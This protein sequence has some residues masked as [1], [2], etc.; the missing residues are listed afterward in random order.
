MKLQRAVIDSL[1][2]ANFY[3]EDLFCNDNYSIELVKGIGVFKPER[4]L[5]TFGIVTQKHIIEAKILHTSK[6][7]TVPFK[8]FSSSQNMQT[9]EFAGLYSYDEKSLFKR[10]LLKEHIQGLNDSFIKRLDVAIDFKK[11]IPK[12]II[13]NICKHRVPFKQNGLNTNYFKTNSEKKSNATID[14]KI[15]DKAKKEKLNYT[16]TR[17]EFCFKGAYFNKLKLKDIDLVLIKIRKTIK[18]FTGLNVKILPLKAL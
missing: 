1:N 5:E 6:G 4:W 16:L 7:L 9:V 3:L 14:I 18:K 15:Y 17:L 2:V 8:R 13:K 10:E 11:P 12:A